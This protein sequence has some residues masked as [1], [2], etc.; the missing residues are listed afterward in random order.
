MKTDINEASAAVT[1]AIK[2][3]VGDARFAELVERAKDINARL[4]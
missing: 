4:G 1:R 3:K 2:A